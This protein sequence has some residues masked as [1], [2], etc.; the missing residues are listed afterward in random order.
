[1]HPFSIFNEWL[2]TVINSFMKKFFPHFKTIRDGKLKFFGWVLTSIILSL[3]IVWIPSLVG[4][5]IEK[6]LFLKQMENNP[7]V[8][9]SIVFLGNV[10]SSSINQAGVG[11]N[12]FATD[13]RQVTIIVIFLYVIVLAALISLKPAYNVSFEIKTQVVL[14][15]IT[16]ALGI[17]AYGF[18]EANWEKSVDDIRAEEETDIKNIRREASTA[19]EEGGVKL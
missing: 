17:Y 1:M 3:G 13:L 4:L 11:S 5:F 12:R 8:I 10:I 18:R 16:L 7:V 14:L 9:F 6:N 2:L 15:I 19:H